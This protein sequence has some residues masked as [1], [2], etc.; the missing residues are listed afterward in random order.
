MHAIT[1]LAV[2]LVLCAALRLL[3]KLALGLAFNAWLEAA[4][5]RPGHRLL[6]WRRRALELL[7]VSGPETR[8]SSCPPFV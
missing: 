2:D 7:A 3:F 5:G 8:R 4:E 6:G 1:R